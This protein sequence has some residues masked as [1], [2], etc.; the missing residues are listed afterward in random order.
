MIIRNSIQCNI[1]KE[2]IESTHRHDFKWCSCHIFDDMAG[3]AVDGGFDYM[4]RIGNN[5][6]E[7][8][9]NELSPIQKIRE[10]FTYPFQK[11]KTTS[12]PIKLKE[13]TDEYLD[14][15]IGQTEDDNVKLI[16]I[17]EKQWR[18]ELYEADS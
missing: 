7:M 11:Y 13:I 4:R 17:Q 14:I 8:C 10:H 5:Y 12:P 2:E 9:L 1:C 16:F 15:C 6:T 18:N 3:C